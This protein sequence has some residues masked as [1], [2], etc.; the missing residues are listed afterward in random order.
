V[1]RAR[2]SR[3]ATSRTRSR[4][5]NASSRL[6][7]RVAAACI[8]FPSVDRLPSTTSA[9]GSSPSLFGGF[10]GNMRPSDFPQAY[11]PGLRFVTLPGRPV[12]PSTSG[13]CGISRFPRREFPRMHRVSDCAG[14][15]GGLP[16]T[17][18]SVWPS[19]L[20]NS[21]DTLEWLISQLD[22]WPACAPVNA[23]PAS[24]RPPTH[25]SGSG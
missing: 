3:R 4:A 2:R 13:A 25:D 20:T 22:G 18:P 16:I 15:S 17:P 11:M 14:S 5:I 23:S 7:V 10:P 21:V 19:A 6:C 12:V 1:N 8:V 24:L 9:D